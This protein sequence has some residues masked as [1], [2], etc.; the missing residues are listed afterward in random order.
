MPCSAPARSRSAG[1]GRSSCARGL[2]VARHPPPLAR[3]RG[4]LSPAWLVWQ[5]PSSRAV[6]RSSRPR[7]RQPRRCSRTRRRAAACGGG[8]STPRSTRRQR[9]APRRSPDVRARCACARRVPR[10]DERPQPQ[11]QRRAALACACRRAG[12]PRGARDRGSA[13][14]LRL[15]VR[16]AGPARGGTRRATAGPDEPRRCLAARQPRNVDPASCV[17]APD[18][19]RTSTRLRLGRTGGGRRHRARA[20][21]APR[22][23]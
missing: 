19:R 9:R 16:A 6:A 10:A 14:G 3:V 5:R 8:I 13:A 2:P 1:A 18:R 17:R 15:R 12:G 21:A 11:L 20:P 23:Q 7:R 22:A 4:P